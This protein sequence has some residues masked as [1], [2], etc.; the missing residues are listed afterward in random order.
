[1][2]AFWNLLFIIPGTREQRWRDF[3]LKITLIERIQTR[4][5]SHLLNHTASQDV[6][7]EK[8]WNKTWGN[9]KYLSPE[10]HSEQ[11]YTSQ[12]TKLEGILK[13]AAPRYQTRTIT[14]CLN[15]TI[16]NNGNN[17]F[18]DLVKVW[19]KHSK[20]S[21]WILRSAGYELTLSSILITVIS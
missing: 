12:R 14:S 19:L 1:M 5:L 13:L 16:Y 11:I 17:W 7:Y 2:E 15:S 21:I 20:Q 3:W 10:I 18:I 8:Y 9:H 4:A 6:L